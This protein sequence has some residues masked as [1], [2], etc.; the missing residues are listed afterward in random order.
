[1]EEKGTTDCSML[2]KQIAS[3]IKKEKRDKW[4][5]SIEQGSFVL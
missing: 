3:R 1:M 4:C 2:Q 5:D